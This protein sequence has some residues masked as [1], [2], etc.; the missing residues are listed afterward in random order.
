MGLRA[1]EY[2]R[3]PDNPL[4]IGRGIWAFV[5]LRPMVI[6]VADRDLAGMQKVAQD[7]VKEYV[8]SRI[9]AK[10]FWTMVYGSR[11]AAQAR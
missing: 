2:A 8:R 4:D 3:F 9:P 5:P 1:R 10:C 7:A 11:A 6:A